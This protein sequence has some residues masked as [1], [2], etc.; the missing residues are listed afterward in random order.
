KFKTPLE[1]VVSS[2]RAVDGW[3]GAEPGLA[4]TLVRLGQPLYLQ[5]VPTGYPETE[6][7]WANSAALFERMNVAVALA[8]DRLPGVAVD[9]ESLI[10]ATEDVD[11]LIG[12]VD[13]VLLTG[14][15]SQRTRAVIRREV[16]GLPARRARALAVGLTLGGPE[17]QVQ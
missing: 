11:A 17:F 8:A 10:P 5:P 12:G 2:V 15:M 6:A 16:A 3:A 7:A 1:F 4:R 13:R 9:L 14:F